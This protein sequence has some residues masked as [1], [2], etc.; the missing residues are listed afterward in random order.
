MLFYGSSEHSIDP[1]LRLAIPARFRNQWKPEMDGGA[2]ICVPWP[3]GVL[4]LYTETT[5]NIW[6][7]MG[8]Q[9]LTPD[10]DVL[11]LQTTLFGLA[12]RL[13]MDS[14]GRITIPKQHL[15]LTKLGNEVAVTSA[16]DH[17]QVHPLDRWKTSVR[18]SFE[19]LEELADRVGRK[20]GPAPALAPIPNPFAAQAMG[21]ASGKG[22]MPGA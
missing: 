16:A 12:E 5:F 3:T 11:A 10:R 13:E 2:W 6:A 14:A 4:R 18:A 17:A 7:R 19:Q 22:L 15:E 21:L 9:T 20:L 8:Y 1:K